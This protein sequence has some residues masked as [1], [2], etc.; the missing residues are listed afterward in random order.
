MQ[1]TLVLDDQK[2][3]ELY[4]TAAPEFKAMLEQSFGKAHF[5]IKITDRIKSWEDVC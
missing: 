1:K 3:K 4:Q 2:A 5:L